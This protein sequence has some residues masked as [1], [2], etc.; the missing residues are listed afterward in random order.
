[1][2]AWLSNASK[3]DCN[4]SAD[5][6]DAAEVAGTCACGGVVVDAAACIRGSVVTAALVLSGSDTDKVVF[7]FASHVYDFIHDKR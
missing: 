4:E 1:M 5:F 7:Q 6:S 3:V 2:A